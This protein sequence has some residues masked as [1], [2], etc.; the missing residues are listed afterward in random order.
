MYLRRI[1]VFNNY[2]FDQNSNNQKYQ[3]KN[4]REGSCDQG[5]DDNHL[6]FYIRS[7][8]LGVCYIVSLSVPRGIYED[9]EISGYLVPKVATTIFDFNSIQHDMYCICYI[10]PLSVPHGVTCIVFVTQ[11]H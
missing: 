9:V 10:V 6:D 2:G 1:E 3:A 11:F 5:D 7:H 8:L 4:C